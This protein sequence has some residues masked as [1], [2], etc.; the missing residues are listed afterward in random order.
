[1]SNRNRCILNRELILKTALD[2]LDNSGIESLSMREIANKLGVKAM[3]LYNHI[4]NKEDLLT[5]IVEI[6]L[7]EVQYPE[8]MADWKDNVRSISCSFHAALLRHPHAIFIVSTHSPIT[9]N[10][11]TH[12]EKMLSI[13]NEA[14]ITG[15]SVFSLLHILLAYVIGHAAMS[16]AKSQNTTQHDMPDACSV[17][18]STLPNLANAVQESSSRDIEREFLYGLDLMLKNL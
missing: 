6:I 11:I 1:M 13:L 9:E 5:G 12:V 15:I 4:K 16:V 2:I 17:K 14:N 10:G 8:L 18:L 3:S 7:S